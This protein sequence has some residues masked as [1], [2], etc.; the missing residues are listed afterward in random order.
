MFNNEESEALEW[1]ITKEYG[2]GNLINVFDTYSLLDIITN[3]TNDKNLSDAMKEN[4]VKQYSNPVIKTYHLTFQDY[5][6][7]LKDSFC[8]IV[9]HNNEYDTINFQQNM[10]NVKTYINN[11]E[12]TD[13]TSNKTTIFPVNSDLVT[14]TEDEDFMK[15]AEKHLSPKKLVYYQK[16][17][18]EKAPI[19]A[20]DFS[21]KLDKSRNV[22]SSY[23]NSFWKMGLADKIQAI[24]GQMLF[25]AKTKKQSAD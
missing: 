8:Y 18:L 13:K 24:D 2:L 15:F 1:L 22:T 17:L 25:I 10:N 9:E 20:Q 23:L 7:R 12:N 16:L 11:I 14:I 6:A 5:I 21:I 19:N 4:I 3:I